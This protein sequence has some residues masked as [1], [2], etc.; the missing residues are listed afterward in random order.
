MPTLLYISTKWAKAPSAPHQPG[1][2][3]LDI[4]SKWVRPASARHRPGYTRLNIG[5][6][7]LGPTSPG[8]TWSDITR[9]DSGRHQLQP[10]IRPGGLSSTS[11]RADSASHQPCLLCSTSTRDWL[12]SHGMISQRQRCTNASGDGKYPHWPPIFQRKMVD[13]NPCMAFSTL[14]SRRTNVF[15][16]KKTISRNQEITAMNPSREPINP[17]NNHVSLKTKSR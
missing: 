5:P 10:D 15:L 8:S 1:L 12:S 11:A 9:V 14:H 7:Q 17:N 4:E 13:S 3:R 6:G 16:F 2:T